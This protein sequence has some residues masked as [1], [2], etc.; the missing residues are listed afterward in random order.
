MK[1]L[2]AETLAS[3]NETMDEQHRELFDHINTF[4]DSVSKEFNHELSVRTLNF[5]VKYV[6]FHFGT[7]EDLMRE[8]DFPGLKGHMADHRKLVDE[9]MDCYKN[10]IS[11]GSS[12]TVMQRLSVLLQKWFVEH[13]MGHDMKLAKHLRQY[14]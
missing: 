11:E 10:L 14:A 5:L 2:W 6:R 1:A 12:D 3:G 8:S 4:F 7:E 9:L 13:I